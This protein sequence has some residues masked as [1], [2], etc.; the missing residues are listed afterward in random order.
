MIR[1]L[2]GVV[3]MV[4]YVLTAVSLMTYRLN[5]QLPQIRKEN[6]ERRAAARTQE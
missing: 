5:K 3:P 4:L 1:L 6:E 2:F